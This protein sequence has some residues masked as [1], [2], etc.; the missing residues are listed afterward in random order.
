MNEK[1]DQT[2]IILSIL[3]STIGAIVLFAVIRY[4][5]AFMLALGFQ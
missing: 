4:G 5:L 2:D 1:I 3:F